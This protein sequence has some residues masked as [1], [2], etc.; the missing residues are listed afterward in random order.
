MEIA[1]NKELFKRICELIGQVMESL[2]Y[3]TTGQFTVKELLENRKLSFTTSVATRHLE[4]EC[5]I[6]LDDTFLC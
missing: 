4:D 5:S 6:T 3:A 1:N 2:L